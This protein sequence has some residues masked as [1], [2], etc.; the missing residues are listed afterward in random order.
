M[1]YKVG[2]KV[3]VRKDLV[4]HESYYMEDG[5]TRD[6]AVSEMM[7]HCGKVVTI[8]EIT[9]SGKYQ[10]GDGWNWTDEM[11]ECLANESKIVITSDGKTTTAHMYDGKK[12]I[13]TAEAKC[14]PGDDFDFE[15]GAKLAFE[16][17]TAKEE[18][19]APMIKESFV[20]HLKNG[21]THFGNIG[22]ATSYKDAIGRPLC[23]GDTVELYDSELKYRGECSIV[24]RYGK[25]FV[26][27][28]ACD[29]DRNTGS[30]GTWK[31]IKK[32]SFDEVKDGEKVDCIKYI[33]SE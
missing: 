10:I 14:A 20:P 32:R 5:L 19:V 31:I 21:R 26:M 22:A 4:E 7:G 6:S 13:K 23:I 9:E 33:K 18:C 17:L 24:H 1:K 16:R 2:D 15:V 12:V 28:I 27:G 25:T 30:T 29:C 8:C 3:V 11:F